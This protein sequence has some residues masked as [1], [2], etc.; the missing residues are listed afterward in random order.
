LR[1]GAHTLFL[2]AVPLNVHLLKALDSGPKSVAELRLATG[3]PAETTTREHL[4]TLVEAGIVQRRR[5]GGFPGTVDFA[6]SESGRDVLVVAGALQAWL[7]NSPHGALDLGSAGAKGAITALVEGW[8]S[9]IISALA[10][11]PL[12]LTA[13]SQVIHELSYPS[14]ERRLVAMRWA[15]QIERHRVEGPGTPYVVT[16]WLRWAIVPL[17]AAAA[18]ERAN[19]EMETWRVTPTD[20]EATLLL[21]IPLV[22]LREGSSGTY[23]FAVEAEGEARS[24]AGLTVTVEHGNI[25][26]CQPGCEVDAHPSVSGSPEGWLDAPFAEGCDLLQLQG[27]DPLLTD[28]LS[29]LSRV[30]FRYGP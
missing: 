23:R 11:K 29:G 19:L 25:A 10:A 26:S 1:A 20:V 2:L 9:K 5:Q 30:L 6:L 14:L 22:E 12:A 18:W 24:R 3:S 21:A 4:A 28:M 27:P 15:G 13:L 17:V 16:D 7:E 8:N